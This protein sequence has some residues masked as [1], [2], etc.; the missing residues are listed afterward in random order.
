MRR[1]REA[2]KRTRRAAVMREKGRALRMTTVKRVPAAMTTKNLQQRRNLC[3][4]IS[5][6]GS[7]S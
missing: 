3:L 4:R 6:K 7:L 2:S 1:A 5:A